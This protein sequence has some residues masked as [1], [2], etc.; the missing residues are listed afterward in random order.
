MSLLALWLVG[1]GEIWQNSGQI[2]GIG[3]QGGLIYA[4]KVGRAWK[5]D[6]AEI[7]GWVKFGKVK[8]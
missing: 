8:G 7:N 5:S 1:K 2:K 4:R 6:A 3:Q